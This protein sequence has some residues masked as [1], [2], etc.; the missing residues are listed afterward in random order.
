MRESWMDGE[1]GEVML[2]QELTGLS[3]RKNLTVK[4]PLKHEGEH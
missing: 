2:E 3:L 1:K 4:G